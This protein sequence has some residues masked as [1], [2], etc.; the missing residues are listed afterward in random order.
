[1]NQSP[2]RREEVAQIVIAL[3]DRERYKDMDLGELVDTACY[4]LLFC[5]EHAPVAEKNYE[6]RKR[7][8]AEEA[9]RLI[10]LV[11]V[12]KSVTGQSRQTEALKRF[13][14]LVAFLTEPNALVEEWERI[15]VCMQLKAASNTGYRKGLCDWL[16]ELFPRWWKFDHDQLQSVRATRGH[17]KKT[18]K[19]S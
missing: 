3:Q 17:A 16:T 5:G 14:R 11:E 9:N 6:Q 7:K 10:P 18:Q 4:L 12:A 8:E 1:V 2:L 13:D 19:S 15:Q